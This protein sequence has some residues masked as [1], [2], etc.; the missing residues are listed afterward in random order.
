MASLFDTILARVGGKEWNYDSLAVPQCGVVKAEDL[1]E[2]I[3]LHQFLQE[4]CRR[5]DEAKVT[6]LLFDVH[7]NVP[8][9]GGFAR[10]GEQVQRSELD[11]LPLP[12][13]VSQALPKGTEMGLIMDNHQDGSMNVVKIFHF[14]EKIA[15]NHALKVCSGDAYYGGKLC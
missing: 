11:Q 14:S 4:A 6:T 5:P 1:E 2:P 10:I 7:T 9:F 12:L 13:E 3:T 15:I 8:E